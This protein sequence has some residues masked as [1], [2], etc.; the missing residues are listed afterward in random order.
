[1]N[2]RNRWF[3]VLKNGWIFPWQTASHNQRV[4]HNKWY[5]IISRYPCYIIYPY[6]FMVKYPS[7]ISQMIHFAISR[8]PS[9]SQRGQGRERTKA[10]LPRGLG[11]LCSGELVNPTPK[12][13]RWCF[14]TSQ[15]SHP[16][17]HHAK[18]MSKKHLKKNLSLCL[19]KFLKIEN[20]W[21]WLKT[22]L[23]AAN[24]LNIS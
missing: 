11:G 1:M 5:I 23:C 24:F 18:N 22:Y 13:P 20:S 3:T 21:K 4:Y 8:H 9:R 14:A 19:A 16:R 7:P 6:Q 10:D 15:R 17:S 2:H 12:T